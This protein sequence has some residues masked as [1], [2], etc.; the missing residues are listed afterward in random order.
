MVNSNNTYLNDQ[1]RRKRG[2]EG[3]RAPTP[4]VESGGGDTSGYVPLH[5]RPEQIFL[6]HYLLIF[7]G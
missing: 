3:T 5:F 4:T 6:I 7:C 2:Q 1:G